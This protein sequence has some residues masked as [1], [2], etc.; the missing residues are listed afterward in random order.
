MAW[1]PLPIL[2]VSPV[3]EAGRPQPEKEAATPTEMK[4][5]GPEPKVRPRS[6]VL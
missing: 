1:P 2:K 4:T 5:R 6:D 3:S